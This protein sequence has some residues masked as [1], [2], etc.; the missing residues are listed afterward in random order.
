MK[1]LETDYSLGKKDVYPDG[2]ESALQVLILC[3]EKRMRKKKTGTNFA[4]AGKKGCWGCGDEGHDRKDCPMYHAKVQAAKRREAA[5]KRS[6]G[7]VQCH[8]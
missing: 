2:I 5:I 8:V 4:Q 6:E 1:N 3:S 7:L